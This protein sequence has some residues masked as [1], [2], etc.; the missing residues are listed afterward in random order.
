MEVG[1]KRWDLKDLLL[2][3]KVTNYQEC[4]ELKACT[5]SIFGVVRRLRE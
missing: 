1:I 4:N 2:I 3:F 5:L